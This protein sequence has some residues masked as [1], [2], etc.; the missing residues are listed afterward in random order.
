MDAVK[1]K[2]LKHKIKLVI[3]ASD[4]SEKSKKNIK[5]VCT[6]S[7]VQVIEFS[8]IEELGN[9]IGKRNRAIIGIKD[10]SFSEGIT[11][12]YSGGDLLW[13]K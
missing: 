1:E 6:N 11:N 7:N 10:K 13:V 12:K 9:A 8:T 5:F 4:T 2:I 3:I